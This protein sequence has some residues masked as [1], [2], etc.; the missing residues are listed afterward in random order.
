MAASRKIP[1]AF[2]LFLCALALPGLSRG[3]V[4]ISVSG[5]WIRAFPPGSDATAAYMAI[6]NASGRDDV[7]EEVVCGCSRKVSI[8]S[9]VREE[10]SDVVG[11]KELFSLRIPSGKG[12][13]LEPGGL[14]LMLEGVRGDMG[15]EAVL[16]LRFS[17]GGEIA[18]TAPVR[19][20]AASGGAHRGHE[21]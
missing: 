18:V 6:E 2:C 13:V 20:S 21:H 11:M 8:H 4:G 17:K 7:L 9:T 10:G 19:R 14:H 16:V 3:E 15:A 12:A 1:L 5:A